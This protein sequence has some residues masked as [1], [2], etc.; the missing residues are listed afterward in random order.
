MSR[1]ELE[2]RLLENEKIIASMKTG[3]L[4]NAKLSALMDKA[5]NQ[6]LPLLQRHAYGSLFLSNAS[7]PASKEDMIEILKDY[8]LSNLNSNQATLKL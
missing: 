8:V 6:A 5:Y 1:K 7:S 3:N 4:D 2:Q